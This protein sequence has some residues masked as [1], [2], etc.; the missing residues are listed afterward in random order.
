M[1]QAL[2][3]G[4][5]LGAGVLSMFTATYRSANDDMRQKTLQ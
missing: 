3:G 1:W 2:P 5:A 4:C